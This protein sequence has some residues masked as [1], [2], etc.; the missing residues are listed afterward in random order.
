MPTPEPAAPATDPAGAP[1]ARD[2]PAPRRARGALLLAVGAL[3][4]GLLAGE[5]ILRVAFPAGFHAPFGNRTF[6]WLSYDGVVAW[7]N[8]PGYQH[9]SF[10][11]DARRLVVGPQGWP[12]QGAVHVL[13][14]GDSRTF[15]IWYDGAYRFDAW[16]AALQRRADRAGLSVAVRNAGT[17]G[18]SA[19]KGL[20]LWAVR[21]A[22]LDS[23]VVVAAFGLNDHAAAWNPAYALREPASRA[24]RAALRA[25]ASTRWG[26]GLLFAWRRAAFG[27]R[28]L[29]QLPAGARE[30][31]AGLNAPQPWHTLD[32]Y[33]RHLALLAAEARARAAKLLFLSI[34]L[35][36]LELGE[37]E[38]AAPNRALYYA[39]LGARDLEDLHRVNARYR[40]A[41]AAVAAREGVPL[42]DGDAAFRAWR[43]RHP[44]EALFSSE[45]LV[46]PN[47]RGA[48]VLAASVLARL[49]ELGWLEAS[50]PG[51]HGR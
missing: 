1:P 36:P 16:P 4:L 24:A 14:L 12:S 34:P 27:R 13:C 20:R 9:P 47:R 30:A 10:A 17:V 50:A 35:R 6:P 42:L 33:E 32:E 19:A 18:Y 38:T 40:D 2:V 25:A 46:H 11:I 49:R 48:D 39:M 5:G 41:L 51:S 37:N 22:D 23:D 29:A 8:Q 21:L 45:D 28:D 7:S 31:L 15:G 44:G 43:A 26:E 3:A